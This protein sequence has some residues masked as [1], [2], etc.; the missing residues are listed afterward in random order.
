MESKFWKCL[1]IDFRYMVKSKF[2]MGFAIALISLVGILSWGQYI[3]ANHSYKEYKQAVDVYDRN[4]DIRREQLMK[5]T[6]CDIDAFIVDSDNEKEAIKM[7]KYNMV[8]TLRTISP[9]YAIS[10]GFESSLIFWSMLFFVLGSIIT[11][12]DYKNK[13]LKYIALRGGKTNYILAKITSVIIT[14]VATVVAYMLLFKIG[15]GIVNHVLYKKMGNVNIDLGT[16][17]TTY[18]ALVQFGVMTFLAMVFSMMGATFCTIFKGTVV[19][20]VI[21]TAYIYIVP[22]KLKYEPNSMVYNIVRKYFDFW[23]MPTFSAPVKNN[24]TYSFIFLAM[25]LG[26]SALIM[27]FVNKK[28]SAYN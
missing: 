13:T 1:K 4:T 8:E 15:N 10:R 28:R 24:V 22:T 21:A 20:V 5:G 19:G 2:V 26:A 18:N 17:K 3:M 16:V 14:T 7:T 23:S 27:M 25:I 11:S 6:H 9:K 12:K